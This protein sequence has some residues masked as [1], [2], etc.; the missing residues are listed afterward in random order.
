[1]YLGESSGNADLRLGSGKPSSSHIKMRICILFE[2]H[3]A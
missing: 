1:M 3:E 2:A